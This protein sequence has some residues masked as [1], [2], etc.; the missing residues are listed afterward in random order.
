MSEFACILGESE[1]FADVAALRKVATANLV[2]RVEQRIKDSSL[3]LI[4]VLYGMKCLRHAGRDCR[5]FLE[6]WS[7][8]G[9]F[10]LKECNKMLDYL[11]SEY[12]REPGGVWDKFKLRCL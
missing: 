3:P 9:A 12:G 10:S 6:S 7:P 5:S 11:A 1:P 4:E 8:Q 2:E